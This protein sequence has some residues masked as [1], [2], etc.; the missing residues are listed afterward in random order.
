MTLW[1]GRRRDTYCRGVMG[2][3]KTSPQDAS[4]G[5]E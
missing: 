5:K 2:P 1:G 4:F 3:I